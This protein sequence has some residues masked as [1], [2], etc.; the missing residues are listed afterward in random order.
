[1][2]ARWRE[3]QLRI[4]PRCWYCGVGVDDITATLDHITPLVD[5]GEDIK[6][7][8]AIACAACNS[9]K[10]RHHL[11]ELGW[12]MDFRRPPVPR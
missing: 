4:N 1:M 9:K 3:K 10:G 6:C 12:R 5:G 8:W 2:F 7:N 11:S